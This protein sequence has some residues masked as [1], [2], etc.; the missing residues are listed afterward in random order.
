LETAGEMSRSEHSL[1]KTRVVTPVL[2]ASSSDNAARKGLR[3]PAPKPPPRERTPLPS[4]LSE[5]TVLQFIES[6]TER[7]FAGYDL[8]RVE[9][10]QTRAECALSLA[11]AICDTQAQGDGRDAQLHFADIGVLIRSA[12]FGAERLT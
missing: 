1:P 12:L 9:P 5:N 6:M 11:A 7:V 4:T 10:G 2:R 3:K 8:L